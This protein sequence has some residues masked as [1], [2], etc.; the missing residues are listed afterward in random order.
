[1]NSTKVNW[2]LLVLFCVLT[3]VFCVILIS[4]PANGDK[5]NTLGRTGLWL[6]IIAYVA[7]AITQAFE[8]RRKRRENK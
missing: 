4:T 8:I 6:G 3:V 7:S 2:I 1:M 5:M